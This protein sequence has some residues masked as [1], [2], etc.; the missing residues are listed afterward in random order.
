MKLMKVLVD[1]E[2]GTEEFFL[3]FD[4]ES[5]LM[6]SDAESV[7]LDEELTSQDTGTI[8]DPLKLNYADYNI[9]P[10]CVEQA[11]EVAFTLDQL[12]KQGKIPKYGIFYKYLQGFLQVYVSPSE[13]SWDPEVMECLKT[14]K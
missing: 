2:Y 10:I 9:L 12:V 14:L 6:I 1:S 8:N 7:I 5:T 13:Y 3:D 4:F 11:D